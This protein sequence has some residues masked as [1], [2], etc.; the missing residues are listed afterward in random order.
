MRAGI[1]GLGV[2][3]AGMAAKL[4]KS[5]ALKGAWN[6]TRERAEAAA[7]EYALPLLES[8]AEV[9]RRC[10]L[11]LISVSADEDVVR[12]TDALLPGLHPDSHLSQRLVVHLGRV[13]SRAGLVAWVGSLEGFPRLCLGHVSIRSGRSGMGRVLIGGSGAFGRSS[14][15]MVRKVC[16]R[17]L[18]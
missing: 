8:P 13:A 3:G 6:R 11:I 7:R 10:N 16:V 12:V 4:A 17:A 18:G 15:G 1:I 2:M 9:A 5:G 14:V